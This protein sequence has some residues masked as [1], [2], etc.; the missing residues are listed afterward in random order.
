[1]QPAFV[2]AL[3]AVLIAAVVS[4]VVMGL[5]QRRRARVLSRSAHKMGLRFS[6]DDP[7]DVPRRYA[8]FVLISCGHSAQAHNVTYGRLAG[9]PLRAFDFRFEVG[10]GTRRMTRKYGVIVIETGK[11]SPPALMWNTRDSQCVP[12]EALRCQARVGCWVCRGEEALVR[13]LGSA[14]DPLAEDAL[15]MQT[16]GSVLMMWMPAARAGRDYAARL[17]AAGAIA[18]ALAGTVPAE[19]RTC[20]DKVS[21]GPN[22]VKQNVENPGGP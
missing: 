1:M 12:L 8:D 3:I 20:A 21:P 22:R 17:G 16:R 11:E 2:M 13:E 15:S 18:K 5:V 4:F 6:G 14:A 7:F 10:H 19:P 9:L